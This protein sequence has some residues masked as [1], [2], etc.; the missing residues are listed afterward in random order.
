M[1]GR[2]KPSRHFPNN[3]NENGAEKLRANWL[4]KTA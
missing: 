2:K 3:E 1:M 4:V